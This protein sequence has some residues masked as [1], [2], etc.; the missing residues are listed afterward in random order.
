M[1]DYTDDDSRNVKTTVRQ[2][3]GKITME[4]SSVM[5]LRVDSPRLQPLGATER[6]ATV[7]VT[8]AGVDVEIELDAAALDALIDDLYAVQSGDAFDETPE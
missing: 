1:S 2:E 5:R 6:H 4:S 8:T 3:D 7:R